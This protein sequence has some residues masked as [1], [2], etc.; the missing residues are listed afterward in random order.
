LVHASAEERTCAMR[1]Q[2]T[3][4]ERLG[5]TLRGH[6]EDMIHE[7]LPRQWVDL[8]RHLNEEEL[9]AAKQS[10]PQQR[11]AVIATKKTN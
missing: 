1:F 7:P 8:I 6:E 5:K 9:K 10:A 4:L 2:E 11:A 3:I